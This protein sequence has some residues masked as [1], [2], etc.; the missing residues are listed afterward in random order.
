MSL[1]VSHKSSKLLT[2][3]PIA[4]TKHCDREQRLCQ[5]ILVS[6]DKNGQTD[7]LVDSGMWTNLVF[8]D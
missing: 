2:V 8:E 4:V 6:L 3:R 5:S 1:Q 7:C